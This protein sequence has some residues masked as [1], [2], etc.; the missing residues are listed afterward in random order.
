MQISIQLAKSMDSNYAVLVWCIAYKLW[1][2]KL[3]VHFE[4]IFRLKETD[5]IH[6]VG[7]LKFISILISVLCV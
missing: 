7:M 2:F 5:K 4:L 1:K 3:I 6:T